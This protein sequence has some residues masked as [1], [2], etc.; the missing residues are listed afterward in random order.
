MM[1]T[2]FGA[3]TAVLFLIGAALL[4]SPHLLFSGLT[5]GACTAL[6]FAIGRGAR[7]GRP[8]A[9]GAHSDQR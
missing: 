8:T 5:V 6:W 7:K 1:F 2:I 9:A 3:I 4:S